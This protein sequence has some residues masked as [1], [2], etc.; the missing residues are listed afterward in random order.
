MRRGRVLKTKSKRELKRKKHLQ[1]FKIKLSQLKKRRSRQQGRHA[2]FCQIRPGDGRGVEAPGHRAGEKRKERREGRGKGER[3]RR[4]FSSFSS[5]LFDLDQ[6][7][8][9]LP[10]TSKPSPKQAAIDAVAGPALSGDIQCFVGPSGTVV[11]LKYGSA[12]VRGGGGMERGKLFF[13][14]PPF[15]FSREKKFFFS[16]KNNTHLF[17]HPPLPPFRSARPVPMSWTSRSARASS[18]TSR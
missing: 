10:K 2:A 18:P 8:E 4:F 16:G 13:L 11:G 1:P 12:Q 5:Q 6:K 17:L 7:N 15:F 9:N 14:R 3:E